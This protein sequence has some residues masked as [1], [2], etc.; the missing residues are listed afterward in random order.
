MNIDYEAYALILFEERLKA[1]EEKLFRN[2][3]RKNTTRGQQMLLSIELG[4]IEKLK[5][6]NL[7]KEEMASFLSKYLNADYD[8]IYDDLVHMDEPI[9]GLTIKAN[10]KFLINTYVAP[11]MK[12][13]REKAQIKLD[14]IEKLNEKNKK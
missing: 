1:V 8:N 14:E 6:F 9:N 11:G 5:E 7:T 3:K 10:Y 13:L 4:V 2:K 12:N